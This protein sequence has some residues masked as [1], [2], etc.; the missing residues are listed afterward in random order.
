MPFT[1]WALL[2]LLLHIAILLFDLS[3]DDGGL[4]SY[5]VLS[6]PIWGFMYWL[7]SELLFALNQGHAIPGQRLV[8]VAVGLGIAVLMD[9]MI[10]WFRDRRQLVGA[11]PL[12]RSRGPEL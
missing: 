12:G 8:V 5:L 3:Y 10:R 2:A 4:G 9:L 6:S 11:D 1:L 7:P